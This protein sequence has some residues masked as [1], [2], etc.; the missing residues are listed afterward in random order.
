MDVLTV[1]LNN[2]TPKITVP[3]EELTSFDQ[4]FQQLISQVFKS[5][6]IY[7]AN[8]L[9]ESGKRFA[10]VRSTLAKIIQDNFAEVNLIITLYRELVSEIF[11]Y[12]DNKVSNSYENR[13]QA[14]KT[15]TAKCTK[16]F[17][18]VS[19]GFLYIKASNIQKY[20]LNLL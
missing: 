7:D 8:G 15:L 18:D 1:F 9:V 17:V 11:E 2:L 20:V 12:V 5:G 16:G 14:L 6:D 10:K 13:L 19:V 4:T 3:P